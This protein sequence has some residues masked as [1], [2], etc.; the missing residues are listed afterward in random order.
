MKQ[1]RKYYDPSAMKHVYTTRNKTQVKLWRGTSSLAARL[2][3]VG[4]GCFLRNDGW[5]YHRTNKSRS[6]KLDAS[7][8]RVGRSGPPR[9]LDQR[10]LHRSA[11]RATP[12]VRQQKTA[13]GRRIHRARTGK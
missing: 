6:H 13:H 11:L 3:S 12:A 9:R 7:K 10:R 4:H 8:N 1:A 2:P 5:T